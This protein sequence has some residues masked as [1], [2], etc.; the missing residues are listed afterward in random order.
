M[1]QVWGKWGVENWMYVLFGLTVF[2]P[3]KRPLIKTNGA[4]QTAPNGAAL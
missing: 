1:G 2:A 3:T 4:A